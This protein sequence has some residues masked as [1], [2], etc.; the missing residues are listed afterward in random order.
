MNEMVTLNND[1]RQ[2][3]GNDPEAHMVC[4]DIEEEAL[5]QIKGAQRDLGRKWE[6]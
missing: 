2:I 4:I 6:L 3:A 1:R 5:R